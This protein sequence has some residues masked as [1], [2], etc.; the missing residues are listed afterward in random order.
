L[1]HDFGIRIL[2]DIASA[3]LDVAL[4][5]HDPQSRLRA[6]IDELAAEVALVLW[7]TLIQG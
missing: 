1:A 5:G 3:H 6:E 2:E 4:T 7:D